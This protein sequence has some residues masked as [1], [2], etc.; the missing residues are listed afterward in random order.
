MIILMNRLRS[1]AN[2]FR[3][4]CYNGENNSTDI[5]G[6][7]MKESVEDRLQALMHIVDTITMLI[8][9][10]HIYWSFWVTRSLAS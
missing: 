10:G 7:Q 3:V 8:R 9:A 5:Y 6:V 1:L 4:S 2:L